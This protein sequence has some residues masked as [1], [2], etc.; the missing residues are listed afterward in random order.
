MVE[1]GLWVSYSTILLQEK[2]TFLKNEFANRKVNQ[3][4]SNNYQPNI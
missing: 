1:R 2:V 4:Q 3:P